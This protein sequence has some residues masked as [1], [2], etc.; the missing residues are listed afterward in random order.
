LGGGGNRPPAT[1]VSTTE[2]MYVST[3]KR[4]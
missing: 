1:L 4:A 3:A 2:D